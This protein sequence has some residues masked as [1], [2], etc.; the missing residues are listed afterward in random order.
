[1]LAFPKVFDSYFTRKKGIQRISWN[2]STAYDRVNVEGLLRSYETTLFQLQTRHCRSNAQLKRLGIMGTPMC[3]D[4][5]VIE[6][7]VDAVLECPK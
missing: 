6:D 1:M 4:Y 5:G 3:S 7:A 2:S